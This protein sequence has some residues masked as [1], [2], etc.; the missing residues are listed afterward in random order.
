MGCK[1]NSSVYPPVSNEEVC[2]YAVGEAFGTVFQDYIGGCTLW[3][4]M[5]HTAGVPS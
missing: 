5:Q 2:I 3:T 1:G 4:E